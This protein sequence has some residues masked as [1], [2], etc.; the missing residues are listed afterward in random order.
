MSWTR[1]LSSASPRRTQGSFKES[2]IMSLLVRE[3][4]PT[5]TLS[6][7]DKLA[8]SATFWKVRPMPISAIR[9]GGAPQ[10]ALAFHQDI[11][12]AWLVEPRETIE[13]GGLAGAI[14]PDQAENLALMH[15]EGDAIERDDAAEHDAD[16]ADCK[17]GVLSLRELCL[18]HLVPPKSLV[19]A[20]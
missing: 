19:G 11:A 3:W 15:V 7:T 1:L 5:R 18:R 13:E 2:L 10:N 9:C 8:N 16:V 14:R 6:S 17:Q 20:E 12:G 4:V